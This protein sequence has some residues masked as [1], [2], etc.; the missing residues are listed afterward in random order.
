MTG[1]KELF[2]R[3]GFTE[4]LKVFTDYDATTLLYRHFIGLLKAKRAS[5]AY[6]LIKDELEQKKIIEIYH[7]EKDEKRIRL[8]ERG[9]YIARIIAILRSLLNGQN[10][11]AEI[12]TKYNTLTK[13]KEE[14]IQR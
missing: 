8:T 9:R 4:A 1:G 14:L 11:M 2:Q 12:T 6:Y 13:I 5:G 3:K 10:P 7:P